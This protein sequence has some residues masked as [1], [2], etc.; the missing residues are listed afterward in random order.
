MQC[1]HEWRTFGTCV[2]AFGIFDDS[3]EFAFMTEAKILEYSKEQIFVRI[4]EWAINK[5]IGDDFIILKCAK[6][7]AL[8][9]LTPKN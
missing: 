5:D 1:Q 2:P 8:G 7:D 4:A 9:D 6:C 3:E